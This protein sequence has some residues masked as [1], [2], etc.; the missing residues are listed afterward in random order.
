MRE[1]R[2]TELILRCF[3]SFFFCFFF[4][5]IRKSQSVVQRYTRKCSSA[6]QSCRLDKTTGI[7]KVSQKVVPLYDG[8]MTL[9][10]NYLKFV[11]W[12]ISFDEYQ[13]TGLLHNT[14]RAP[15][16]QELCL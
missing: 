15:N 10:S 3:R 5:E 11:T 1:R 2:R 8:F 14:I 16:K 4:T 6:S 7:H 13:F 12:N 9:L